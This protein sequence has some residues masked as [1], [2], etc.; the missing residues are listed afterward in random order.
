MAFFLV[1][2]MLSESAIGVHAASDNGNTDTVTSL[3]TCDSSIATEDRE[4][5]LYRLVPAQNDPDAGYVDMVWVNE[6]N[7]VL[8]KDEEPVWA[9]SASLRKSNI[10]IPSQY[11]L[12]DENLVTSVKDQGLEGSC[13]AFAGLGAAESNILKQGLDQYEEL[14]EENLDFSEK[15]LAYFAK[16]KIM[17]ET[18]LSYGDGRTILSGGDRDYLSIGGNWR[19][20][21]S[22]LGR[23]AGAELESNVPYNHPDN[24]ELTEYRSYAQLKS[25]QTYDAGE[26]DAIKACIMEQG[27]MM[28]SYYTDDQ[29]YSFNTQS[30]EISYFSAKEDVANHAILIAGW[31][32]EYAVENF[33][34]KHRPS[35]P[36]AWL[37]RNSWG[38]NWGVHGNK[39]DGYFWL[40]YEEP[41]L[42]E[43]VSVVMQ[44]TDIVDK[45]YGYDGYG[46]AAYYEPD[47]NAGYVANVFAVQNPEVLKQVSTYTLNRNTQY[48]LFI[49]HDTTVE[50]ISDVKHPVTGNLLYHEEGAMEQPGYHTIDLREDVALQQGI[51]SVVFRFEN[52]N[53]LYIPVE[54]E[55]GIP[56]N[57]AYQIWANSSPGQS[58]ISN[59]GSVWTDTNSL[60]GFNN[61]CIKAFVS[62][63]EMPQQTLREK[64]LNHIEEAEKLPLEGYV[65]GYRDQIQWKIA[66]AREVLADETAE[67][68]ALT[69]AISDMITLVMRIE[70]HYITISTPEELVALKD[71]V[72]A[73]NTYEGYYV[74]LAEDL[75]MEGI[76]YDSIGNLYSNYVFEGTFDGDGHTVRNLSLTQT[77]ELNGETVL[78]S[79][80]GLFGLLGEHAVV[81][82]VAV[83]ITACNLLNT[84]E[85]SFAGG[86][87]ARTKAGSLIERSACTAFIGGAMVS[88]GL[89]GDLN[90]TMRH[91]YFAGTF[92]WSD[93]GYEE[94]YTAMLVRQGEGVMEHCFAKGEVDVPESVAISAIKTVNDGTLQDCYYP[95]GETAIFGY[96]ES[97]VEGAVPVQ[98][99]EWSGMELAYRLNCTTE[100]ENTTY[101]SIWTQGDEHPVFATGRKKAVCKVVIEN[102]DMIVLN[103]EYQLE[104]TPLEYS[105]QKENPGYV[106]AFAGKGLKTNRNGQ[107][108]A[109]ETMTGVSPIWIKEGDTS[110]DDKVSALDALLT[111]RVVDRTEEP[112]SCYL[113]AAARDT[114]R[115]VSREDVQYL[116]D[117]ITGK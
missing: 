38:E 29:Y 34:E 51:F 105:I 113:V 86:L 106:V 14:D 79:Y 93:T 87:A 3:E 101:E 2:M 31:D 20:V 109:G 49:Y 91:C 65:K 50:N 24:G 100:G 96:S 99:E 33:S 45:Q 85:V 69:G 88:G 77:S 117:C 55:T 108:L 17:D 57:S 74:V 18:H 97:E 53:A 110:G 6:E 94:P 82:N 8:P 43:F 26:K 41:S 25:A 107:Y 46:Y 61:L 62:T 15:H 114:G 112:D 39:S 36:G 56:E 48:E 90:G 47:E 12:R 95:K 115:E 89:V 64:L 111:V 116:L 72:N 32:D 30:G 44:P 71:A 40:S 63:G 19:D 4:Y 70:E 60:K 13:W 16:S 102:N 5:D 21:A 42:D 11:D 66:Q 52:R 98:M 35:E 80:V 81:R 76:L 1:G 27:A 75:D 59:A 9:A 54:G 73:G 67:H 78:Y 68:D 28:A 22:T 83:E 104:G 10:S 7:Q 37:I 58:Y 92:T 103:N 23:W 84:T